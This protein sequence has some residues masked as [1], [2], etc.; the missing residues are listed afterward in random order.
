MTNED[1]QETGEK[2]QMLFC[3]CWM[4]QKQD[5][6]AVSVPIIT[7]IQNYLQNVNPALFSLCTLQESLTDVSIS[8]AGF[9]NH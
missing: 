3:V 7:I 9:K 6:K 2:M 4:C 1:R 8:F 5:F